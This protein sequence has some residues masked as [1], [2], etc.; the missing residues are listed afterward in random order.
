VFTVCVSRRVDLPGIPS[1]L[2]G[3]GITS[4]AGYTV[5]VDDYRVSG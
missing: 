4:T 3:R 2:A 5:H 1:M